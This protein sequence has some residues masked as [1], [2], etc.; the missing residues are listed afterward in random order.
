[1]LVP[2]LRRVLNFQEFDP[3]CYRSGPDPAVMVLRYLLIA[4][5]FVVPTAIF[6]IQLLPV[7]FRWFM[8]TVGALYIPPVLLIRKPSVKVTHEF[9]IIL[10][11]PKTVDTRILYDTACSAIAYFAIFGFALFA[12]GR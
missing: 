7:G 8:L 4:A 1:M 10:R 3:E 12:L 5:I 6:L 2:R 11:N 9:K